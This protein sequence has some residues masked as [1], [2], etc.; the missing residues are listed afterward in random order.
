MT[1]LVGAFGSGKTEIA[2]N[3]ALRMAAEGNVSLVDLDVVTPYFR[4]RD[5]KEALARHG[6]RVITPEP[7]VAQAD[8]PSIPSGMEKVLGSEEGKVIIDVGGDTMGARVLG[9][10]RRLL[11]RRHSLLFVVNPFRPF[12]A[13]VEKT[14]T[15]L[16]RIEDTVHLRVTGLIAN[17][18]LGP[19][20]TWETLLT[21]HEKV[22]AA[23]RQLKL[24][25]IFGTYPCFLNGNGVR[26]NLDLPL[27]PLQLFMFPP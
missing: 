17:S 16:R 2:L 7:R 25:V 19:R 13:T 11:P 20:T 27:M 21:G 12:T 15:E 4:S 10:L 1:I 22:L 23:G 14:V 24:P 18:N 3:L 9:S 8:L 5:Q 6:V 26:S